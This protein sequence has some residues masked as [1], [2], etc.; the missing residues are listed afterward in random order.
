MENK[1]KI[2]FAE[3]GLLQTVPFRSAESLTGTILIN[4]LE[5]ESV[6]E[7]Q[8][9]NPGEIQEAS[10]N[11]GLLQKVVTAQ[12]H[13]TS[14]SCLNHDL[15]AQSR[16]DLLAKTKSDL[17]YEM[18]SDIEKRLFEKYQK[19][20]EIERIGQRTKW[21]KFVL[22]KFGKWIGDIYTYIEADAVG[23]DLQHQEANRLAGRIRSLANKIAINTRRGPGNFVILPSQL[24]MLLEECPAYAWSAEQQIISTNERFVLS[25]TLGNIQVYHDTYERW[26]SKNVLV[27]RKSD[28]PNMPGIHFIEW[29][30]E[31]LTLEDHSGVRLALQS[32]HSIAEAG[33]YQGQYIADKIIVGMKPWWRKLFNL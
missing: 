10:V 17:Y 27:G 22:S 20:G 5:M 28:D 18:S 8:L 23:N 2:T 4:W 14:T 29:S 19:S 3:R 1:E 32:R 21:Q 12:T 26:D 9:V 16:F 6:S 24:I 13:R 33:N 15:I 11:V 7:S 30:N 25:G 31:F